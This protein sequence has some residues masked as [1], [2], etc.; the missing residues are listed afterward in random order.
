MIQVTTESTVN[1]VQPLHFGWRGKFQDPLKAYKNR[2]MLSIQ[3]HELMWFTSSSQV[4][5]SNV[6]LSMDICILI[7]PFFDSNMV[8]TSVWLIQRNLIC[9]LVNQM[10]RSF[11]IKKE[12]RLASEGVAQNAQT[13]SIPSTEWLPA[14]VQFQNI[15][16]QLVFW[17]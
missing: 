1:G 4:N 3:N 7:K 5:I 15:W 17:G 13:F 11:T 16:E 14:R 9:N 10:N 8:P 2:T 6:N 12:S